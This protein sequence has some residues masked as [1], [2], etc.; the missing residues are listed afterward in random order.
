MF[1]SRR[2]IPIQALPPGSACTG[3]QSRISW[4]DWVSSM[5]SSKTKKQSGFQRFPF[6]PFF[7]A[8]YPILALLAFNISEL[9]ISAGIR[10]LLATVLLAAVLLLIFRALYHDLNRGALLSSAFLVLFFSYGH[11]FNLLAG[12]EIAGIH[13]F[14]HR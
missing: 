1:C 8:A 14:Q 9:N 11:I 4:M 7:F 5:K 10:S 2:I 13:P 12:T 3:T 6:H